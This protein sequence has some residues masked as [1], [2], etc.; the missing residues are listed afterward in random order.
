MIIVSDRGG[1]IGGRSIRRGGS[2]DGAGG[3]DLRRRGD[4]FAFAATRAGVGHALGAGAARGRVLDGRAHDAGPR[5]AGS[6]AAEVTG[7]QRGALN[8][9]GHGR[10]RR[11]RR[12]RTMPV[13]SATSL[14]RYHHGAGAARRAASY[15]CRYCSHHC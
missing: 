8:D 9:C 13:A 10:H 14:R 1:G 15:R 6:H 2:R 3:G 12:W 4:S 11:I 5:R 7:A